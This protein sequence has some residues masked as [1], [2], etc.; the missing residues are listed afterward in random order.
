MLADSGVH[1]AIAGRYELAAERV[2]EALH[3]AQEVGN[4]SLVSVAQL[5]HGFLHR[6]RDPVQA[7]R[8]FR[9]AA[10]LADTVDSAWTTGICRGELMVLQALH[11]DPTGAIEL[12]TDQFLR[13]RRAGDLSRAHSVLRMAIP[14]IHRSLG[15]EHGADIVALEAGTS[16][17]PMVNEPFNNTVIV[18]VLDDI[19]QRLDPA[20][21][22]EAQARGATMDDDALF[23]LGLHLL[24]SARSQ[25]RP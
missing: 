21:F 14:A 18:S 12:G 19:G 24:S 13:F 2:A 6:E 16:Q 23:E 22:S 11:G 3:L 15:P 8:W 9:D 20:S 4:P 1:A 25:Q 5:A 17:R 10:T 7:I